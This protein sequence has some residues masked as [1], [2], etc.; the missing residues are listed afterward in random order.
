MPGRAGV[1][2]SRARAGG[3][4]A[5]AVEGDHPVGPTMGTIWRAARGGD[6]CPIRT[7]APRLPGPARSHQFAPSVGPLRSR[8][9]RCPG[10]HRLGPAKLPTQRPHRR[11]LVHQLMAGVGHRLDVGPKHERVAQSG[12]LVGYRAAHRGDFGR[13]RP[14]AAEVHALAFAATLAHLLLAGG[15]QRCRNATRRQRL[16]RR[17]GGRTVPAPTQTWRCAPFSNPCAASGPLLPDSFP[18]RIS[19]WLHHIH[20]F[21]C[22]HTVP[23]H[24]RNPRRHAQQ[25]LVVHPVGRDRPLRAVVEQVFSRIWLGAPRPSVPVKRDLSLNPW[26]D[27]IDVA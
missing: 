26:N 21:H 13:Q 16:Q 2:K 22:H 1:P 7:S 8:F 25:L 20:P 14:G 10:R 6:L 27:L 17:Q 23:P 15:G 3:R 19:R 24:L 9:L 4:P 18:I 11:N 12:R 5:C